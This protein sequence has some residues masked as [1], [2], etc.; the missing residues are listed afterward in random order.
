M[1]VAFHNQ[2]TDRLRFTLAW[3][4]FS[5]GL[6]YASFAGK[7]F[8]APPAGPQAATHTT[9]VGRLPSEVTEPINEIVASF[10]GSAANHYVY[11]AE[12]IHLTI[13]N[14]DPL[15][16]E[17]DGLERVR[18]QLR[19]LI[20]SVPPMRL[21]AAGLGVSP[22]T[23]FVQIFPADESL[24]DLRR[25]IQALI[26]AS[27]Q[28][29]PSAKAVRGFPRSSR[30]FR[31][32]AFANVMRFSGA[33]APSVVREITRHRSRYFGA[34]SLETVELVTTDRLLS[35]EGTHV[36]ERISLRAPAQSGSDEAIDAAGR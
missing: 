35:A 29:Y 7:N 3:T 34:F 1:T 12:T 33:V 21:V 22:D 17:A 25:E 20:G 2:T 16:R 36:K 23:V 9:L 15:M 18:E 32:L 4:I 5:T 13:Q 11:P 26:G 28:S 19:V 6:R 14:L 27:C 8:V 24:A 31:N 30:L 10:A